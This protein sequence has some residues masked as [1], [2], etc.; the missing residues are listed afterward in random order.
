M[1]IKKNKIMEVRLIKKCLKI[2]K[3]MDS[4]MKLTK[5]NNNLNLNNNLV[6]QD[7]IMII[8]KQGQQFKIIQLKFK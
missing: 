5:N 8:L 6:L 7:Q 4:F 3:Y 2:K 1:M